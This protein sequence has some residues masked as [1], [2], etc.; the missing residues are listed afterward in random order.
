M[1]V[2]RNFIMGMHAPCDPEEREGEEEGG[3]DDGE[4][5][6]IEGLGFGDL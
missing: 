6:D 3:E 4:W 2:M 1:Q 5:E